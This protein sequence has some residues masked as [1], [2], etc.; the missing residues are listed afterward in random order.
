M[1]LTEATRFTEEQKNVL[2]GIR[3]FFGED[4]TNYIIAIFSHATKKQTNDKNVMR[5]AWNDPVHSFIKDLENRW[6]IS[7]DSDYFPPD[8]PIHKARLGEI[9]AFI[10]GMRKVYTTE[11]LEKS[12]QE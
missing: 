8:D 3:K 9:M 11:Q 12:R 2:K 1:G 5:N 4:A 7:P 10:S 6:G